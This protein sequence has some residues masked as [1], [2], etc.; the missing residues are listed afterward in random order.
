MNEKFDLAIMSFGF[1]HNSVD[2]C[3]YSKV[4]DNHVV[5]ICLYVDYMLIVSNQMQV[6]KEIKRFLFST[7]KM[8]D[9]GQVDTVLGIKVTKISGS[10]MLSH[11]IMLRM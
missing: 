7:Y 2:K 1:K 3:L 9:L 6:I 11:H 5:L 4:C 10:Y 8:K